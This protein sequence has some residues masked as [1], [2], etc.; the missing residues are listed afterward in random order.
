[1]ENPKNESSRADLIWVDTM[2]G[3][4]YRTNGHKK[5]SGVSF[6]VRIEYPT[7]QIQDKNKSLCPNCVTF[8]EAS[9]RD[10]DL[11]NKLLTFIHA[12]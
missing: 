8:T 11:L 1:M 2:S 6:W 3:T 10:A 5:C 7:Q 4:T 9:T 12:S